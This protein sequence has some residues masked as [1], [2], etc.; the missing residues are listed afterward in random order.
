VEKQRP[1][2]LLLRAGEFLELGGRWT[3]GALGGA[4]EAEAAE[5]DQ[6]E[7]ADQ[8]HAEGGGLRDGA[9]SAMGQ[10]ALTTT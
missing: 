4:A 2:E 1:W 6:T 10:A 8:D 7:R 5:A 9:C 3:A